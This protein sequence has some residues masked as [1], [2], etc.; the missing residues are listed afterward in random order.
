[1]RVSIDP[2]QQLFCPLGITFDVVSKSSERPRQNPFCP[3]AA[4]VRAERTHKRSTKILTDIPIGSQLNLG[5]RGCIFLPEKPQPFPRTR[6]QRYWRRFSVPYSRKHLLQQHQ[7][8]LPSFVIICFICDI[9]NRFVFGVTSI[10]QGNPSPS[11]KA[12]GADSPQ[13]N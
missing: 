6:V 7:Q 5:A 13:A 3:A 10:L 1:M 8:Q 11:L 2:P 4:I 9:I 12:K